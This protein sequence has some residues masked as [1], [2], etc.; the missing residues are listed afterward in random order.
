[1]ERY[2]NLKEE[3]GGS[4]P[5]CKISSLRDEKLAK[6]STASCALALACRP[7][8]SKIKIMIIIIIDLTSNLALKIQFR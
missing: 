3:V 1:M 7:Y 2:L 8:V 5:G 4:I 6:W